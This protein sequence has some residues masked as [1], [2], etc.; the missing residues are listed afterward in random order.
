MRIFPCTVRGNCLLLDQACQVLKRIPPELYRT[1]IRQ[2]WASV[3]SQF[4]HILDH[5][6]CFLLGRAEGRIDYDARLRDRHIETEAPQAAL[7]AAGMREALGSIQSEETDRRVMVQMD[8]GGGDG[9]PD[10]R[11]STVGRELQFLASHTVHHF[12]L[13]KLLLEDAGVTT[14]DQFGMAPSSLA[15]QRAIA[16]ATGAGNPPEGPGVARTQR[17]PGRTLTT[18]SSK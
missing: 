6:R 9:V 12:A 4:R 15:Y 1:S 8:S 3:G 11:P 16:V 14:P 10:W 18:E 5:Y 7:L 13:I 2:G 17:K